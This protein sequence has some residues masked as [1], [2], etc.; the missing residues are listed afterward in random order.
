MVC[1]GA[2]DCKDASEET[3]D[4]CE[5]VICP[6]YAFRCNYGACIDNDLTC[7]GISNCVDNS[8][9]ILP[10]CVRNVTK[11][12]NGCKNDEFKCNNRECISNIEVCDGVIHC[13]DNS[14]ETAAVC[15]L[16]HCP[17]TNFRCSY[18]ACIDGDRRCDGVI[19]CADGSDEDPRICRSSW[20]PSVIRPTI[21]SLETSNSCRIPSQPQNGHWKLH[22]SQCPGDENCDVPV[23][24]TDLGLG[25][26]LVYSCNSGYKISSGLTDV[27]C[28]FGGQWL[29]IP[30]CEEIRCPA[31]N[32]PSIRA[33]CSYDE[34]FIPCG[35]PVLPMTRADV[36]CANSYHLETSLILGRK[37]SVRCNARGQW[38]PDLI[39]CVPDCGILPFNVRPTSIGGYLANLTE[40][41]WHASLYQDVNGTSKSFFC[42]ASIVQPNLL[43]TAA[44]CIY[45]DNTKE[46]VNPEE[47]YIL[48]GNLYRE[49]N[50]DFHNQTIVKSNKV[51]HIYIKRSYV[52]VLGNYIQ[53]IAV[54]EVIKPF[55]LSAFL[56]PVCLGDN[57]N[58]WALF[59]PGQLGKVAGFGI[60]E[61]N[62]PS[63]VLQALTVP[64]ITHS[65]CRSVSQ[66]VNLEHFLTD[67]KFCAGFTNGSSVCDGDSGGGLVF[68]A[69]NL[70]YLRGI[71]STSL[72]TITE[73]GVARCNNNLYSLFTDVSR[74]IEWIRDVM[75]RIDHNQTHILCSEHYS[76]RCT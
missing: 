59:E 2:K 25:S 37:Q 7:N 1:D 24:T 71:V 31:L 73:G 57:T 3:E 12:S 43:I 76:T 56:V 47:I 16:V 48:T 11:P 15:R 63:Q 20:S 61:F 19:N 66:S 4:I 23:G 21:P 39:R 55:E 75:F 36:Y 46:V 30:I 33:E 54:L 58:D 6:I 49:Y 69:K 65:E 17:T 67:D 40:F 52:G 10:E 70:Y 60:T 72:G 5:S 32:E 27:S 22:S 74:H 8:D 42:G 53:D 50:F 34:E 45:N 51:K 29:N 35:L 64:L 26:R 62:Q 44:H 38:V 68:K 13:R 14:D 9:E 41:P 18:G 28:I